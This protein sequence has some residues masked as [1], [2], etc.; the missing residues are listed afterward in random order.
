MEKKVKGY[1]FVDRN[2][3]KVTRESHNAKYFGEAYAFFKCDASRDKIQTE[4]PTVCRLARTD[5]D[6]ELSLA[7]TRK[8]EPVSERESWLVGEAK[9]RDMNYMLKAKYLGRDNAAAAN[10]VANVINGLY[11]DKTIFENSGAFMR[12][13]V[14]TGEDCQYVFKD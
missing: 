11:S 8:H 5:S 2:G 9:K 7:E 1:A 12:E 10:E 13:V 3:K 14:Y 6:L 4:L